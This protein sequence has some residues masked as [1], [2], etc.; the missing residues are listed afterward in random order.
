[1]IEV[2]VVTPEQE[3][4]SGTAYMVIA[5]GVDGM[6]GVLSGHIPLLIRLAQAPLRIQLQE[7]GS[8]VVVDVDGGFL[9]VS[10]GSE[11]T[12]VD[13]MATKAAIG[14]LAPDKGVAGA[15]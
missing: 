13:V 6:V 8:E 7:G 12:R 2:H 5:R 10:T 11:G 14:E 1:M 4:W 15:A 9:H 3:V